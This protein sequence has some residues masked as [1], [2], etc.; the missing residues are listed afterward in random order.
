MN[1]WILGFATLACLLHILFFGIESFAP[2]VLLKLKPDQV[3]PSTR[4][5][6]F[7]Q[8]FYNL[9]LAMGGLYGVYTSFKSGTISPILTFVLLTMIGA[10]IVLLYSSP[11]LIRG[12]LAQGGPPLISLILYLVLQ[13]TSH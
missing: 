3:D 13:N 7:N 6:F 2:H 9:F 1:F 10:A 12:A 8:G 11:N 5:V 4:L